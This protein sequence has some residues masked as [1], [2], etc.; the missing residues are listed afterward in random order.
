MLGS[1]ICLCRFE[2]YRRASPP[3]HG[4]KASCSSQKKSFSKSLRGGGEGDG[5]D[6]VGIMGPQV[7]EDVLRV[8]LPSLFGAFTKAASGDYLRAGI[9]VA[10]Q[11]VD[12]CVLSPAVLRGAPQEKRA[13]PEMPALPCLPCPSS[14][15]CRSLH[16]FRRASWGKPTG[17]SL[18]VAA[19]SHLLA[20]LCSQHPPRIDFTLPPPGVEMDGVV[21]QTSAFNSPNPGRLCWLRRSCTPDL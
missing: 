1:E 6:G 18:Q 4:T 14:A 13:A 8:L 3:L 21:C 9:M 19:P 17:R 20:I 10:S 5:W 2:L 15:P 16:F 12:R 7:S 11:L